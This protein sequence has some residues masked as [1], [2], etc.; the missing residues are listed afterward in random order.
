M[1]A[2]ASTPAAAAPTSQTSETSSPFVS[3]WSSRYRGVRH[4][5]RHR[6]PGRPLLT[7]TDPISHA[8]I[9]AFERD[10]THLTVVDAHRALVGYLAIPHLQALLDAG[11]VKPE[12]PLSKAMVRFQRKGR[13]YR[14]ITMQ[15]PLEELEAFFA[16]DGVEAKRSHFAVIT[17]EKRRFVL[18]VATVQD[19]EEFVK[20]RPA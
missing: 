5:R 2:L 15:T 19:L 6:P 11:K 20:R 1:A 13:T 9:S 4:S 14:V 8:L 18:G 3:K 12:D 17:D 10:Y 16:G 7:P